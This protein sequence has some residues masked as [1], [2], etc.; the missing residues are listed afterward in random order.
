[1]TNEEKLE[2]L[3]SSYIYA[4]AAELLSD[5]DAERMTHKWISEMLP[6]IPLKLYKY[7]SCNNNNLAMLKNKTAWFSCPTTWNDPVDVT[8]SYDKEKDLCLLQEHIDSI[9][10]KT[11]FSLINQY[12][13]S[14]CEQKKFVTSNQVKKAYYKAFEGKKRL[15]LIE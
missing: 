7:R 12:I 11:A 10:S 15:V 14:F 5:S 2:F 8:V 13:D 4:R 9:V 6:K 1:M 3:K